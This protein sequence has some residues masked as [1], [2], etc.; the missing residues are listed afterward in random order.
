M[1]ISEHEVKSPNIRHMQDRIF[2]FLLSENEIPLNV[3][4]RSRHPVLISKARRWSASH[5][6]LATRISRAAVSRNPPPIQSWFVE[7]STRDRPDY[8]TAN[9]VRSAQLQDKVTAALT[10]HRQGTER[11]RG[12]PGSTGA[13]DRPEPVFCCGTTMSGETVYQARP[14]YWAC[15]WHC[16]VISRWTGITPENFNPPVICISHFWKIAEWTLWLSLGIW[17][18][19]MFYTTIDHGGTAAWTFIY[20][21]VCLKQT[22]ELCCRE[23]HMHALT[24]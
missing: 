14:K 13:G 21:Y 16:L 24:N 18:K 3:V 7:T 20:T 15:Q 2:Q 12:T 23:G 11:H 10:Y 1:N 19:F 4:E 5:K 22:D 6:Y 17:G 8:Q 9:N